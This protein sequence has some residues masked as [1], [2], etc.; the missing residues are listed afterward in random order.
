[1]LVIVA[2]VPPTPSSAQAL[3][4]DSSFIPV[5]ERASYFFYE[6]RPYGTDAYMGPLDV[7]LNKGYAVA[8]FNN[9][10]RY[11]FSYDYGSR[12]VWNSIA[13]LGGNVRRYGGWRR[14]VGD[15]I[16]PLSLSWEEWK[17]AHNYFGHFLEGGMTYRRLA[18]WNRAHRVP[19]ARVSA[20]LV[21]MGAAV[22]NEM[23]A[24]RA[25]GVEGRIQDIDPE[26]GVET[27]EMALGGGVF[28][29]RGGTLLVSV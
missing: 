23:Y 20:A 22:V 13:H 29:D 21:T 1:M 4:P 16:F 9:R 25:L 12:H 19:A 28:L 14:Y 26:T 2:M 18:E 27:P 17:W 7:I 24:H 11:I 5:Q 15:E 10:D 6:G 3:D 8:R